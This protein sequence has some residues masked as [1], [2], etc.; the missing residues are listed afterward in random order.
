[1]SAKNAVT[2]KLQRLATRDIA[3]D[4]DENLDFIM[5]FL[6]NPLHV[7]AISPSS[8][9]LANAM[10]KDLNP[11]EQNTVLEIGVGTGA[12][13]KFIKR[14]LPNPRCYLGI[15]LNQKFVE[16][17]RKKFPDLLIT[18]GDARYATKIAQEANLGRVGYI[19]SSLPFTSLPKNLS[20]EILNEMDKFMRG[21]CI[22][23]TFQYAHCYYLNSAMWFR[24]YM[25]ARYGKCEKSNLILKN[26]PPAYTLTWR[27]RV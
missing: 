16:I 26:M 21:G 6:E 18:A 24:K 14:K 3:R 8:P 4:I 15:E 10:T 2:R 27:S 17:L 19:I 12:I 5:A 1:M 13:T 11:N 7:G 22:F 25:N 20:E 23:R 9:H